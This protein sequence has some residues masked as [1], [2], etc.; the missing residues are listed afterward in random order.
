MQG[1]PIYDKKII[2][3]RIF[4][5]QPIRQGHSPH[6]WRATKGFC[7]KSVCISLRLSN[8]NPWRGNSVSNDISYFSTR[9]VLFLVWPSVL[10]FVIFLIVLFSRPL[11]FSLI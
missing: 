8:E 5:R 10:S 6:G 7:L 1:A 4:V 3:G 11:C 2:V 9:V